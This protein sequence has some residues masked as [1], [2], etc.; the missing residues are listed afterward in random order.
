MKRAAFRLGQA[1]GGWLRTTLAPLNDRQTTFRVVDIVMF[2]TL[3]GAVVAVA[4]VLI[5][6]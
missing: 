5:A 3:I 6:H 2:G 1:K 4:R